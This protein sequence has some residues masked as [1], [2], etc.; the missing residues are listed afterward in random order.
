MKTKCLL[1]IGLLGTI[2]LQAEVAPSEPPD[3]QHGEFTG[4][5]LPVFYVTDVRRSVKFYRDLLGFEFK[6]YYDYEE[7]KQ[8]R[9]W[10]K[11]DAPIWAEMAAGDFIFALHLTQEPEKVVVGGTRHYFLLKDVRSHYRRVKDLGLEIGSLIEKPWMTMFRVIDPDGHELFFS[12]R[13]E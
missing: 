2:L 9:E 1:L 7:S 12:T 4:E 11:S 5:I 10:T 6:H 8:V 3:R 13:T